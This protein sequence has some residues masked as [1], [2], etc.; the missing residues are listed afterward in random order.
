MVTISVRAKVRLQENFMY[1]TNMLL[2]EEPEMELLLIHTLTGPMPPELM[3]KVIE[4]AK[5]M[6][7]DP[8]KFVSGGK[9]IATYKAI[10]QSRII[11]L[12]DVPS[13]DVLTPL[14]EQM[15]FMQWDTEIIPVETMD[16]FLQKAEKMLA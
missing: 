5:E 8:S 14:L 11:C 12:W 10:G 6:A 4:M 2:S 1:Q 16:K 15:S 7:A 3:K 9:A 13:L